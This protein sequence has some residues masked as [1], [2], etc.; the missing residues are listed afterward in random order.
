MTCPA[1]GYGEE[2]A[3][4]VSDPMKYPPN[5]RVEILVCRYCGNARR[6]GE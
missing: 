6:S 3:V 4:T 5:D 1:C 2:R